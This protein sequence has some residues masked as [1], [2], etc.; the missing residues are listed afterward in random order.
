MDSTSICANAYLG[1]LDQT[2]ESVSEFAFLRKLSIPIVVGASIRAI[3]H[4]LTT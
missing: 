2:V 3:G 1:L 4:L